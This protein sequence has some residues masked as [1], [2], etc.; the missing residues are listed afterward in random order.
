MPIISMAKFL[1]TRAMTK[2]E[3]EGE[4]EKQTGNVIIERFN[5]INPNCPSGVLVNNHG[6]F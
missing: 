2:E 6:P 1:C 3:I 4:Y 5:G